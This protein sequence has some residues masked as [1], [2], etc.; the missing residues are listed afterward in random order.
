MTGLRIGS[1]CSGYGGLDLAVTA[2][3]GGSAVW[4]ADTDPAASAVLARHW[5]AV[6]NLG[7]ITAATDWSAVPSVDL[8]VGGYPCQPF[9]AAGP[10]KGV[11][12]ARHL[13][14]HIAAALGVLRPRFVVLENVG[15]HLRLGFDV[16]LADLARLGF[17]A[18]WCC[19]R[20]SDVGAPHPRRRLFVL[21]WS[22]AEDAD[23]EPRFQRRIPA[24]RQAQGGRSRPDA[25]G[26]GR[27]PA[28]NTPGH[29]RQQRGPEPARQ[30][31]R[32]RP[33]EHG[34][35]D[36]DRVDWGPYAPAV[37]RW[38]EAH[39]HPAPRP[40]DAVGRLNPPFVEWLMGLEPGW[41]TA[42]PGLTRADQLRV[43]GNGVVPAQAAHA[44]DLLTREE[45]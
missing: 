10:R 29:G 15:H 36:R 45:A 39:G 16:V 12:D 33:P 43:L 28:P 23:G 6:P 19:V 13:W 31:G 30:E 37:R 22:A 9:S 5:P 11:H 20:A 44:L 35:P 27:A 17:D 42:T 1:L 4:H 7:D 8:V 25:Q 41:V 32:P 26:R 3:F 38:E 40:T 21:A 14:P 24:P 34:A 18:R 2:A